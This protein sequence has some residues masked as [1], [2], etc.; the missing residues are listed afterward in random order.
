[1]QGEGQALVRGGQKQGM[2]ARR[3]GDWAKVAVR[4]ASPSLSQGV[5]KGVRVGL[6]SKQKEI[7]PFQTPAEQTYFF[8]PSWVF[9]LD[10]KL[11]TGLC[12]GLTSDT[13]A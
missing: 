13:G 9:D 4:A 1:M 12:T 7:I 10:S 2:K 8:T 3:P 5:Y 6:V 11:A